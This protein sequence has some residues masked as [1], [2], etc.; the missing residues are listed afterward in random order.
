MSDDQQLGLFPSPTSQKI[1]VSVSNDTERHAL[2][3]VVQAVV[4]E[5]APVVEPPRV[6]DEVFS[7]PAPVQRN[8][9]G[10][11]RGKALERERYLSVHDVAERYA[12]SIQTVWRHTKHNPLFPKPIKIL[13]GSTRWKLS[14]ILAYETARQEVGR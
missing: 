3:S 14:E 9:V 7:S 8:G 13:T 6:Q 5:P 10:P 11:A 2:T 4:A 1:T 12:I